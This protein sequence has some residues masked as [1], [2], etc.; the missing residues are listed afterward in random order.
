LETRPAFQLADPD[1]DREEEYLELEIRYR[2]QPPYTVDELRVGPKTKIEK[3]AVEISHIAAQEIEDHY[4]DQPGPHRFSV[5]V[6]DKPTRQLR[7]TLEVVEDDES[8]QPSAFSDQ[9]E[10]SEI[11]TGNI[12]AQYLLLQEQNR[13]ARREDRSELIRFL[14]TAALRFQPT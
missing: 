6:A 2:G 12:L 14:A 7:F 4:A 11:E 5:R 3:K 8:R 1:G 9:Q 10:E 13:A